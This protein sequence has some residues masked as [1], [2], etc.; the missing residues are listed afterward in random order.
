MR[1]LYLLLFLLSILFGCNLRKGCGYKGLD[2]RQCPEGYDCISPAVLNNYPYPYL[3]HRK[4][5]VVNSQDTL[6]SL[7]PSFRNSRNYTPIDFSHQS[8]I[9]YNGST[10]SQGDELE[11][12]GSLC[13]KSSDGQL[14]LAVD[15]SLS[16]QCLG[17]TIDFRR[18]SA[19]VVLSKLPDDQEIRYQLVNTNPAP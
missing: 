5:F 4:I 17:S 1:N 12:A 11:V 19:Q 15:Y 9:L 14:L 3:P 13:R 16:G 18:F 7:I 10:D 8:L 6:D 2:D